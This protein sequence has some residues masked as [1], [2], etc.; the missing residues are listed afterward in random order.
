LDLSLTHLFIISQSTAVDIQ[1][2]FQGGTPGCTVLSDYA[3]IQ[4]ETRNIL[5]LAASTNN[6]VLVV[7]LDD[8]YHMRKFALTSDA[9]SSGGSKRTVEWAVGSNIF[10]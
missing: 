8:N 4:D 2:D 6:N 9:E 10:E 5:I 7:D 3:F 1:T